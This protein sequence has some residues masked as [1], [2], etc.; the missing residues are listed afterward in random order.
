MSTATTISEVRIWKE[1]LKLSRPYSIAYKTIDA[2]ENVIIS[3]HSRNGLIGLGAASPA[4]FVTGEEIEDTERILKEVAEEHLKGKDL[5]QYHQILNRTAGVMANY[6]AA[7]A[8]LDIALH[9]LFARHL[10][11]PLSAFLGQVHKAIPTSV[12]IGIKDIEGTLE[13]AREFVEKGFRIIK[14]KIGKSMK[15][16]IETFRRLREE[17]G[18]DILIRIDANQ[19]YDPD[20]LQKFA[21][22]TA[23]YKVEF[24]EQPFPT[25][26]IEQMKML[27]LD[28][29]N[30]S[31]ADEDLISVENAIDLA[32][33]ER[34]YG[35]FNIK[36]MK[37]GGIQPAL[38]IA[39]IARQRNIDLM[40]GCNDESL[41][42][43][44]GALHT[45]LAC[46]S[47][48]YLDLDGSL[49]LAKDVAKGGFVLKDGYLSVSDQPGLGT[50]LL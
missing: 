33:P 26:Q 21:T 8:A 18:P 24:Y 4:P 13:D 44:T 25:G 17:V 40:W 23:Q 36:L 50:E 37:C 3:I 14:L 28:L 49:D 47:T 9:D 6:P 22:A 10:D 31:A 35:I 16:D 11:L 20:D 38:H 15:E 48:R 27:P 5:R 43:I 32:V 34:P 42:S 19:G 2:V 41:I 46:P 7:R 12:T 29:R 39:E 45:A 30:L 1:N